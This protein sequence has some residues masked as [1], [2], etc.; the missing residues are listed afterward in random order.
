MGKTEGLQ[1]QQFQCFPSQQET[2]TPTYLDLRVVSRCL[3][4]QGHSVQCFLLYVTKGA[5]IRIILTLVWSGTVNVGVETKH[6]AQPQNWYEKMQRNV[7][8]KLFLAL[9]WRL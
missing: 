3:T 2:V 1:T 7:H 9:R 6:Q 4:T 8:C 5:K